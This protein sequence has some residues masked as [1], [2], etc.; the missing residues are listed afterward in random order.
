MSRMSVETKTKILEIVIDLIKHDH[1]DADLTLSRIAKRANIGKSTIYEHFSNK[2]DLVYEASIY[3]IETYE[4]RF[5]MNQIDTLDF[6]TAYKTSI[7]NM[8][9]ILKEAK[10]LFQFLLSDLK[11]DE[12]LD[13]DERI[14]QCATKTQTKVGDFLRKILLIGVKEGKITS[15]L[16]YELGMFLGGFLVGNVIQYVNGKF[17][18]EEDRLIDQLY[19]YSLKLLNE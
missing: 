4:K 15:E 7:H 18:I 17:N 1:R 6:E 10:S 16:N 8:I 2:Q 12:S 14:K 19:F 9:E 5:L 13:F 3:L 11:A